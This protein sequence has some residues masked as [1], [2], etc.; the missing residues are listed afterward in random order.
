MQISR[1]TALLAGVTLV[2][3]A[4]GGTRF[5]RPR[6]F[7][8]IGRLALRQAYGKRY[9]Q[10]P[11]A[12]MFLK[13]ADMYLREQSKLEHPLTLY[14]LDSSFG[15]ESGVD[16]A[17]WVGAFMVHQ[18]AMSTNVIAVAEGAGELEFAGL[19]DPH[20]NPCSNQLSSFHAPDRA[21]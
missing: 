1:R 20:S 6:S 15:L 2:A 3:A 5:L 4:Y 9:S 17:V 19:F 18:F 13:T 21:A 14:F 11:A 7:A 16:P 10:T 12:E 8:D